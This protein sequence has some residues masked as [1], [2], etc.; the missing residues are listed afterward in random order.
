MKIIMLND[1][2]RLG[3]KKNDIKYFKKYLPLEIKTVVEPFAGSFQVIK[4]IYCDDKYDKIINDNDRDLIEL[5]L[6]IKK[7]YKKV[8]EEIEQMNEI[9]ETK[10]KMKNKRYKLIRTSN[11]LNYR[12]IKCNYKCLSDILQTTTIHCENYKKIMEDYKDDENA[13]IFCD[14][15][16]LQS[17]NSSYKGLT[18]ID[19]KNII[20]NTQMY[21]DL[22]TYLKNSKCKIMIIL[23]SNAIFDYVFKDYIK[24][25]YVK[26]YQIAKH[27]EKLNI[28]C[29]YNI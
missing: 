17:Y 26:I 6:D 16:Y 24:D 9:T 4:K 20:D 28:I 1:V 2:G 23:N 13:F 8:E 21:I 29:N 15:P 10:I 3:N 5:Y 7:D 14:P 12:K 11:F 19:N 18:R 25:S 22:L 27:V